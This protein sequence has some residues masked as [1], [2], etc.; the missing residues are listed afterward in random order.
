MTIAFQTSDQKRAYIANSIPKKTW[1]TESG[2]SILRTLKGQGLGIKEQH[3]Y[4]IR[5]EILGL[6]K[7]EEQI[8]GLNPQSR[9]PR[10]WLS[11][12][13]Y[14]DIKSNFLYRF[15]VT[16]IDPKTQKK[17]TAYFS[18]GSNDELTKEA[19]IA[20][21]MPML[22]GEDRSG[23]FDPETIEMYHTFMKKDFEFTP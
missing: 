23:S 12:A 18:L 16:G 11:A 17:T 21:L 13:T 20:Q 15:E 1:K 9:V 14:W 22:Q 6:E 7:Y 8:R 10:A 2:A 19:A 3:F 5:R 4:D